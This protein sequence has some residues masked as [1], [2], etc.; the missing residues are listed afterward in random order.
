[1]LTSAINNTA[2]LTEEE[3]RK[4]GDWEL[5]VVKKGDLLVKGHMYA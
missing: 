2:K 5:E 3:N 4:N 1:M